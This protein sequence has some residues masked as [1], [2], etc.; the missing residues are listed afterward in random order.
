MP[1]KLRERSDATLADVTQ[2]GKMVRPS[3]LAAAGVVQSYSTIR[4]WIRKGWLPPP[5]E[6][7]NGY[8][9][10]T[11]EQ[12]AEVLDLCERKPATPETVG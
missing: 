7:P 6:L 4:E 11:G 9:Y 1:K 5:R 8:F 12:I 10:W 2:A 3:D